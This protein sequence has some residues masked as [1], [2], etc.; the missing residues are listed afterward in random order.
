MATT[1]ITNYSTELNQGPPGNPNVYAPLRPNQLSGKVRVATFTYTANG[2]Q[3]INNALAMLPSGARILSLKWT[4]SASLGSA[5]VSFGLAGKSGTIGQI[6]DGTGADTAALGTTVADD[7][8][9]FGAL[10]T[11]TTANVFVEQVTGAAKAWLYQT[12]KQV[13]LTFSVSNTAALTT[14]VI[15]GYITYIVD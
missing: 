10:A 2:D 5:T 3:N 9:F 11:N 6:D 13:Y 8:A 12:A 14:Q 1:V 7:T 15:K 4:P